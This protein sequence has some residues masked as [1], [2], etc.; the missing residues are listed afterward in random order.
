M[1]ADFAPYVSE[2][3]RSL[4]AWAPTAGDVSAAGDAAASGPGEAA[5]PEVPAGVSPTPDEALSS[6]AVPSPCDSSS[7]NLRDV[8]MHG[9]CRFM[10]LI[11]IITVFL[12]NNTLTFLPPSHSTQHSQS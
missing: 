4:S 2:F 8:D 9:L 10:D 1:V 6:P 3:D 5:S 12:H 11:I 7:D